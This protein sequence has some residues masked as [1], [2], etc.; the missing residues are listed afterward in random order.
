MAPA[1][2]TIFTVRTGIVNSEKVEIIT[3]DSTQARPVIKT[4]T[5]TR[6]SDYEFEPF[7]GQLLFKAPVPGVWTRILIQ[8]PFA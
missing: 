4:V 2:L 3:R 7:T 5:M 6:F 8:S 1:G